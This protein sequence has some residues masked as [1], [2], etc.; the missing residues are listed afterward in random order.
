MGNDGEDGADDPEKKNNIVFNATS[1]FCRTLGDIPTYGLSGN[2][3]DQ[4]DIMVNTRCGS[5]LLNHAG[6]IV[7]GSGSKLPPTERRW[8]RSEVR[9]PFSLPGA[10]PCFRSV[11]F[12]YVFKGGNSLVKRQDESCSIWLKQEPTIL[13]SWSDFR[14]Q[15]T[16]THT[17]QLVSGVLQVIIQCYKTLQVIALYT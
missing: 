14:L 5:L 17:H 2:R 1:E 8:S 10:L 7:F 3:E 16:H 6:W 13:F 11:D 4:E 9:S 12:V 15:Y